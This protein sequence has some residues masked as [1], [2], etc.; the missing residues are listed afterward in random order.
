MRKGK[1]LLFLLLCGVLVMSAGCGEKNPFGTAKVTGTVLV[2]GA[3]LEGI[4]VSFAL[5]SGDGMS[6][7]GLTDSNGKFTLTS[8][9]APVGSGAVPGEYN[10][11]F[12]KAEYDAPPTPPPKTNEKEE[13]DPATGRVRRSLPTGAPLPPPK[14]IYLIPQKYEDPKTSGIEPVKVEAGKTNTFEFELSSK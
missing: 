6:A 2:D 3:P 11:T 4:N 5:V 8:G 9:G 7:G 1:N 13:V 12:F 10:V 14:P